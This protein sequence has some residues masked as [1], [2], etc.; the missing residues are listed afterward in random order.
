MSKGKRR[1]TELVGGSCFNG[2]ISTTSTPRTYILIKTSEFQST[3]HW[4]G[5][6]E[7]PNQTSVL[8]RTALK[9]FLC[10]Q[11]TSLASL[12]CYLR[13]LVYME[14]IYNI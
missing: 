1:R 2:F 8:T 14:S 5:A 7:T 11:V 12:G 4:Y 13:A 9:W 6:P 10:A 3:Y